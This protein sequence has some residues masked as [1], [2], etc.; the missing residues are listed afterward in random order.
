MTLT[1]G[2]YTLCAADHVSPSDDVYVATLVY[3]I[4]LA[5][6]AKPS[7]LMCGCPIIRYVMNR[8]T[9]INPHAHPHANTLR[10][11]T[12]LGLDTLNPIRSRAEPDNN[13][14][15]EPRAACVR[16]AA[17]AAR[18]ATHTYDGLHTRAQPPAMLRIAPLAEPNDVATH[19][20]C[21]D[22]QSRPTAHLHYHP[23]HAA[24]PDTMARLKQIWRIRGH[25]HSHSHATQVRNQSDRD[26]A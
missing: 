24:S 1:D 15:V 25:G 8:M 2:T 14:G 21:T 13:L 4:G 26:R 9:N 11:S 16:G 19:T 22:D 10:A 17:L 20:Y 7:F 18:A 6:V 23:A 3:A 5:R 12:P